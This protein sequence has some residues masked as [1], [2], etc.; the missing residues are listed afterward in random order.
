[1]EFIPQTGPVLP[2]SLSCLGGGQIA[3]LQQVCKNF[4]C[5]VDFAWGKRAKYPWAVDFA[6]AKFAVGS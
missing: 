6:G 4:T 1:M 3:L 5:A 2:S